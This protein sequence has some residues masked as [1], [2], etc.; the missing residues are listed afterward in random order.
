MQRRKLLFFCSKF[1]GGGA[2]M[3]LLRIIT[4][5]DFA[6]Y[7]VH[8]ALT[9]DGGNYEA[10]LPQAIVVHHLTTGVTSSLKALLKSYLP[11]K[12]LI[13]QLKPSAVI[14]I[15]DPQ[16]LMLSYLKRKLKNA[17]PVI[18]CC[19]NAP[20]K[21]LSNEGLRGK[22]YLNLIPKWYNAATEI[23]AICGGV[24]QELID[25]LRIRVPVK[26]IYN[27]GYDEDSYLLKKAEPLDNTYVR[28]DNQLIACG[29]L[30]KQKGFDILIEALALVKQSVDFNL[31]ILGEG[32]DKQK[33]MELRDAKGLTEN[34]RFAGFQ[35]NPYQFFANADVFV[36]SS[37]W[38]GFGNVITE[39]MIC[40]CAVVSTECDFGPNEIIKHNKEGL[41]AKVED[42]V[43]LAQNIQEILVNK[44]LQEQLRIAGRERAT[45][46]SSLAISRQYFEAI[47]EVINNK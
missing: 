30:H 23:I 47:D 42:A 25:K 40:D 37:R 31:W 43:S 29:R 27:A 32:D 45:H 8:L 9:R 2:E 13:D 35:T 4:H 6:K 24:K 19:Q 17:P 38:E 16:N 28:K 14:S 44:E 39:A 11:L 5:T 7:E 10:R 20:V 21:S 33:L 41:L 3:H 46:F 1:G 18:L 26:V 34:I 36:L 12:K 22:L 15:M